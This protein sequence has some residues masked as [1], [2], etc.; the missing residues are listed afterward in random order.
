M[1]RYHAHV[2]QDGRFWLIYVQ[3]IG[4]YTQ[5]RNLREVETM[6]RDLIATLREVPPDSFELVKDVHLPEK[7]EKHLRKAEER[8]QDATTAQ[9]EAA[10]EVRAAAREL[11]D[12]GL[13]L[14]DVGEALGVSHQRAHQLVSS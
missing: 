2:E 14:R 5:A 9:A 12:S 10:A 1:D 7:V 8:R 6:A 3:E 4:H 11:R 13:S